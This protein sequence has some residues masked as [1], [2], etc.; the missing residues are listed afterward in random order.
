MEV[1]TKTMGTVEVP[2]ERI[3]T[4]PDGLFGFEE[5]KKYALIESEYQPLLLMQSIEEQAL[6]F[7]IIDPFLFCSNYEVDVEDKI[8]ERIGLTDPSDVCVMTIVTL[9]AK[10]NQV[11]ANLE[12]PLIINR[13]NNQC[14]QVILSND[15][16]TT[17]YDI[18]AAL[19]SKAGESQC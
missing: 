11:T 1:K 15:R 9:P 10:G 12:G 17:K 13:K 16:Y 5:F 2:D 3:I 8:L 7:Y 14:L 6:S 4:L 19:K 18:I